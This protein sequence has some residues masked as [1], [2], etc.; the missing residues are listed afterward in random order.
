MTKLDKLLWKI[1][2]G[3]SDQNI[4]F[5]ELCHLA[6]HLGFEERISGSHHIFFMDNISEI[7]NFQPRNDGK[8]KPYQ[9]KQLREIILKYEM[10]SEE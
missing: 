8:A 7:L 1:L 5:A 9:V 4:T 10:G 6:R 2:G 3:K